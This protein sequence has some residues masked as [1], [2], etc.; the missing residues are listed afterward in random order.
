MH[1]SYVYSFGS[2]LKGG[3]TLHVV[4]FQPT[5]AFTPGGQE[6]LPNYV[7]TVIGFHRGHMI[8]SQSPIIS[9]DQVLRL[10][11][12]CLCWEPTVRALPVQKP[13][14]PR[15]ICVACGH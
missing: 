2:G 10:T 15:W 7:T 11:A 3:S 4:L 5:G 12:Q 6:G 9:M 13:L 14:P 1:R 8:G